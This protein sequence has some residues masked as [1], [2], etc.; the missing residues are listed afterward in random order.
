MGTSSRRMELLSS[1]M[2]WRWMGQDQEPS[3]GQVK[4]EVTFRHPGGTFL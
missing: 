2:E 3:W 4:L 1:L